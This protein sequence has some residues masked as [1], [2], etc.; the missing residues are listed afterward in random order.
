MARRAILFGFILLAGCARSEEASV[1]A[2]SNALQ[3][4]RVRTPERDD[5]AVAL[6][7]WRDS[8]QDDNSAL[9][10]GPAGAP[11]LFSLRCVARRSIFL[12]RHGAASSGDLPIM[13][14]S[15]GSETRRLA[16]TNAGGPIPMTRAS[17]APS[18]TLLA[19]LASASSPITVRIG[20]SV[21]L[22]L[23]PDPLIGSFISRCESGTRLAG[24]D[25]NV[26]EA[27]ESA[28]ANTAEPAPAAPPPATPPAPAQR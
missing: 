15:V 27:N 19:A 24:P 4:E 14:V 2:D 9:E 13:L 17:L 8:L 1:V 10:F 6:G 16:V 12:Q 7:A 11:P 23:P 26:V 3:V 5:E 21:P 20:D 18:D 28:E 25:G 22:V